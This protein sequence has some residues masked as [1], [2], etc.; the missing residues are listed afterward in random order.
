MSCVLCQNNKINKINKINKNNNIRNLF[1]INI[2]N[3]LYCKNH[4]TLKYNKYILII[5][6]WY[7]GYKCRKCIN[8]IFINLPDDLQ[9][10]V[11]YYIKQDHYYKN[12]YKKINKILSNYTYKI[13]SIKHINKYIITISELE[14]IFRLL[15][16]YGYIIESNRLKYYYIYSEELLFI[17]HCII[18]ENVLYTDINISIYNSINLLEYAYNNNNNS[19]NILINMIYQFRY[20]YN[21]FK[22]R[23][24]I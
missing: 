20:K 12:Y 16:K 1:L 18:T 21:T 9:Y 14:Q 4:C 24:I 15:S 23:N 3:D 10:K 13:D 5:Q 7:R 19:I 8:N 11:L 17:L 2:N 6:K 22:R